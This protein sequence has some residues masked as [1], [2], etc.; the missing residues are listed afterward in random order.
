MRWLGVL[1]ERLDPVA[2]GVTG[3]LLLTGTALGLSVAMALVP[4]AL[5]EPWNLVA[6]ATLLKLSFSGAALERTVAAAASADAREMRNRASRLVSRDVSEMDEG[7]ITSA[8]VETL[9]ENSTDSFFTPLAYFAL[10]GIPGALAYRALDTVDSTYG[11]PEEGGRGLVPA[12]LEDA[13]TFL[14]ARLA[15]APLYLAALVGIGPGAARDG[16]RTA[17]RYGQGRDGFNGGVMAYYAG[18]LGKRLEKPGAYVM[19]EGPLPGRGDAERA[20]ALFRWFQAASI[21]LLVPAM[22]L[23]AH[24]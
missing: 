3:G 24:V 1:L 2:T 11:Y 5:P 23:V 19:G 13:A 16:L 9:S 21:L 18:A 20:V 10:L 14:P 15:V 4:A 6:A 17:R 22:V 7:H 8:L 12:R